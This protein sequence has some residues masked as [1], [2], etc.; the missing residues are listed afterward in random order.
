MAG[1]ARYTAVL[2]AC[3]LYPAPLRDVLLSLGR[4]GLYHA[5]WTNQIHNEWTRNLRAQRPDITDDKLNR[6][7][8]LMNM[9]IPD[10]LIENYEVLIDKIHLPDPDDRHVVAAAVFGHADAIVTF[11]SERFSSRCSQRVQHRGAAPRRFH[12]QPTGAS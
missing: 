6:T 12:R 3:V 9:A 2:D 11:K 10:C 4:A 8:D 1:S 5:R 7:R